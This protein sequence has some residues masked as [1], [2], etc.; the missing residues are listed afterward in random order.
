[1]LKIYYEDKKVTNQL[2]M[3][4]WLVIAQKIHKFFQL[5]KQ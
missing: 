5:K 4:I 3:K 1:M 2:F